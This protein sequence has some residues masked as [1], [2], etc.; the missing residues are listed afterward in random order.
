MLYATGSVFLLP[1][2][3]RDGIVTDSMTEGTRHHGELI[4]FGPKNLE[5]VS[6]RAGG[7]VGDAAD[8]VRS[9][10]DAVSEEELIDFGPKTLEM[11]PYRAVNELPQIRRHYGEEA[12]AELADAM[13]YDRGATRVTSRMFDLAN[14]ILSGRH[15][16]QSA[17]RYINEHGDYFKIPTKERVD[18]QDLTPLDDDTAIILIAGHRRRR[19]VRHLLQRHNI[20]PAFAR[21]AANLR[22][23]IDF[24]QAIG[25]Q[26]RENVY[27][28][29]S[30][31]DEARAIDLTYRYVSQK[32]GAAP[33][34]R[35]LAGQVGFSETKV[36]DALAFASLPESIQQLTNEKVLPYSTVRQLKPLYDAYLGLYADEPTAEQYRRA[37]K[38]LQVFCNVML[39]RTLTG[40]LEAKRGQLIANAVKELEGRAQYQ[41]EE[42]FFYEESQLDFRHKNSGRVLAQTAL[43]VLRYR[44]QMDEVSEAEFDELAALV[45]AAQRRRTERTIPEMDLGLSQAS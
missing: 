20:H 15:S 5:M 24:G 2:D 19:A 29:P 18:P 34:I 13:T 31:Q 28:R 44:L 25:L 22:D 3:R 21:V 1:Y 11:V 10:R 32:H 33:S 40:N 26:L 35:Q 39:T 36:R 9:D 23:D 42:L 43:S 17:K 37:E 45:D 16:R 7:L 27:D 8:R 12:I 41:Q 4:D 14:P 6:R 30:P 38:E